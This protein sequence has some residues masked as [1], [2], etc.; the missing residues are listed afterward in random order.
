MNSTET[1]LPTAAE[2]KTAKLKARFAAHIREWWPKQEAEFQDKEY[3]YHIEDGPFQLWSCELSNRRM[4]TLPEEVPS[5][6]ESPS[7]P[8]ADTNKSVTVWLLWDKKEVTSY[9]DEGEAYTDIINGQK[10]RRLDSKLKYYTSPLTISA[11]LALILFLLIAT[12]EMFRYTVPD[13]LWSVFTAVVA[14]YFGKESSRR[15]T[16]QAADD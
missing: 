16:E 11:I 1:V 12:M 14:F 2:R 9:D 3:N 7:A 8:S 6:S 5:P 15:S 4:R 10:V 13:Q